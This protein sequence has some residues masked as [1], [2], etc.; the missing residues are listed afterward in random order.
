MLENINEI[1]E[2]VRSL[3]NEKIPGFWSDDEITRWVNEGQEILATKT[4]LLSSYYHKVLVE[5][6]IENGREIRLNHDFLAFDRGG[7][8]YNGKPLSPTSINVLDDYSPNWRNVSGVPVKYYTRGDHLG[9][10]PKPSVGD[11]VSYYGIERADKLSDEERPF[12]NDYRTV[13]F[14]KHIRDYAI[15]HCWYKKNEMAKYA[16][17]MASF[18]NGIREVKA[19]LTKN[20]DEAVF[21]IPDSKH[22][23]IGISYGITSKFD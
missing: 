4:G 12:N 23:G 9:F 5:E 21:M 16:E 13:S 15:A 1:I 10:Y 8:L 6:D 3:I 11:T 14:R 17:K 7:V 22:F 2:D 18:E 19:I 20:E